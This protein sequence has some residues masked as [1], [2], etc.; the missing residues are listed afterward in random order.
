[1]SPNT[2]R[3][4]KYTLFNNFNCGGENSNYSIKSI[5]CRPRAT[6]ILLAVVTFNST[7]YDPVGIIDSPNE[8]IFTSKLRTKIIS[9]IVEIDNNQIKFTQKVDYIFYLT[10]ATLGHE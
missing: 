5:N 2:C 6:K 7:R 10:F 1:M 8:I 3:K 4:N 9:Y